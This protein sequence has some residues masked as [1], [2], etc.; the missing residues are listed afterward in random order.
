M[1]A[2]CIEARVSEA[3]QCGR[4][5]TRV[6]LAELQQTMRHAFTRWHTLPEQVQSDGE[7]VF[8]GEPT[9]LFPTKFSLWLIGLG[10]TH[11]VTRPGRPT[12]NATVERGHQTVYD[13]AIAGQE[14]LSPEQ[15]QTV[16]DQSLVQIGVNNYADRALP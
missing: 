10:I 5:P 16:L 2:A 4:R 1:G 11:T 12:D 3:G 9:A 6:T 15:L 14:H 7:S 8:A 13:Y